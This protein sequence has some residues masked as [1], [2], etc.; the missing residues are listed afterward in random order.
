MGLGAG[1]WWR[2]EETRLAPARAGPSDSSRSFL[3][4]S[5]ANSVEQQRW[6]RE[7]G[8]GG[9]KKKEGAIPKNVPGMERPVL[10]GLRGEK[11][12]EEV[13]RVLVSEHSWRPC[14]TARRRV[15][16]ETPT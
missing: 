14:P 15:R 6:R 7:D 12:E 8:S 2:G 9:A 1:E 13:E 11:E 4:S 5:F 3:M 16:G 10:G